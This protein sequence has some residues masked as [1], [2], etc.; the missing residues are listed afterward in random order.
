[1]AFYGGSVGQGFA[2]ALPGIQARANEEAQRQ[3]MLYDLA[4]KRQQDEMALRARTALG[5]AIPGMLGGQAPIPQQVLNMPPPP[6]ARQT[7][8]PAPGQPSMPRPPQMGA[9]APQAYNP[10]LAAATP[11]MMGM[12][13]AAGPGQ[14]QMLKGFAGPGGAPRT[15]PNSPVPPAGFP[16]GQAQPSAQTLGATGATAG[17]GNRTPAQSL[18]FEQVAD[19]LIKQGV[20]GPELV[21]ALEQFK[22]M[23]DY[24]GRL[25]HQMFMEEL[26]ATKVGN[27][28]SQFQQREKD[29]ADRQALRLSEQWKM[30]RARL[31]MASPNLDPATLDLLSDQVLAGQGLPGLGMGAGATKAAI[32]NAAGRKAKERGLDAGDVAANKAEITGQ[33]RDLANLEKMRGAIGSFEATAKSQIDILRKAASHVDFGKYPTLND[34]QLAASKGAISDPAV[35]RYIQAMNTLQGEMAKIM[36]GNTGASPGSIASLKKAEQALAINQSPESLDA[37]L[38]Q[39]NQEFDNR[40]KGIDQEIND[41]KGAIKKTGAA[42]KTAPSYTPTANQAKLLNQ[43]GL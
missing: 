12:A 8:A 33:G 10:A 37:V 17:A 22:P 9:G 32:L 40:M 18:S 7:P 6:S 19:A 25:A 27:Q 29:T 20:K 15:L 26:G 34:L 24:S 43:Y 14:I 11:P 4:Q 3:M 31:A 28:A 35:N 23:M 13:Q 30:L 41:A 36:S 2:D 21:M 42:G 1:M 16:V 5:N 39:I 38:D